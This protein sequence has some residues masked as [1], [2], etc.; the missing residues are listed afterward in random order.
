VSLD[1]IHTEQE[2]I[3]I[4]SLDGRLTFGM[5]DLDLRQELAGLLQV[6][7]IRV[8]LNLTDL[9]TLD[10]T[11]LATLL[12]A[13][14]ELRKAGGNLALFNNNP[15]NLELPSEAQLETTLEIF[16]TERDAI[17]SFFPDR[18]VRSYDILE[19]VQSE[20]KLHSKPGVL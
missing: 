6:G 11:G 19:F 12:F 3:D 18:E 15:T 14:H 9:C 7:K 17:D 4:L 8:A 1:I 2:G 10:A 20:V 16:L 5:E 13:L